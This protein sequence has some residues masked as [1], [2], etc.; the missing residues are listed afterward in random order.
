MKRLNK[1]D[2]SENRDEIMKGLVTNI[3]MC[4]NAVKDGE[5]EIAESLDMIAQVVVDYIKIKIDVDV[6]IAELSGEI[7]EAEKILDEMCG[8][9]DDILS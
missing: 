7:S 4:N 6:N 5:S 3:M 1:A 8:E 9:H 2:I